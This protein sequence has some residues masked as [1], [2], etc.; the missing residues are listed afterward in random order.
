MANR[1]IVVIGTSA[2]RFEGL[3]F[4]A[5]G[6]NHDFPASILIPIHLPLQFRSHL[7]QLLSAVGPL[8]AT[9]AIEGEFR[10]NGHIYIAPPGRHFLVDKEWLWPSVGPRESNARPAIDAM[11]RSVAVCCGYRRSALCSTGTLGDG[12]S[13]LSA[14][15][16][17]GGLTVVQD[18]KDAAFPGM[19]EN[20]L[21]RNNPDH[22]VYLREVPGL[23]DALVRQPEGD[24]VA[25]PNKLRYEVENARNG[26]AS[27][28]KMDWLG[29]RSVLTCPDCGGI[30]WEIKEGDLS[31]YRCP[32]AMPTRSRQSQ[33]GLMSA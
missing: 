5:K 21:R 18:Q 2:G 11:L 28:E 32:S 33:P 19:P 22:V 10:K 8:P 12:A 17:T 24:R 16:Q 26:P 27:I 15:E 6:F 9:F 25:A 23:L 29:Q 4:L 31:R 20:A 3:C 13:G 30:M 7:D 14:I 1:D